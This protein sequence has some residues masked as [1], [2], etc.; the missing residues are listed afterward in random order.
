MNAYVVVVKMVQDPLT[1]GAIAIPSIK[2]IYGKLS[3]AS[4]WVKRGCHIHE[5]SS[6]S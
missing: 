6:F 1:V 5:P 3:R 2:I 4:I